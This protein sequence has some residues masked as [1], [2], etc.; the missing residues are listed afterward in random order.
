MK[1]QISLDG[2]IKQTQLVQFDETSVYIGRGGEEIVVRFEDV[3][4][5]S[6]TGT[7][8]NN[9]YFWELI[10]FIKEKNKKFTVQFRPNTTLWNKNFSQFHT[11]LSQVNPNAVKTSNRRW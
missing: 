6:K 11:L 10:L 4:S 5:L 7:K 8:L 9:R 3:F 2:I 1:K